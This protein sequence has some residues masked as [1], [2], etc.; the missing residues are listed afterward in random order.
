MRNPA[1][2]IF[3]TLTCN[4]NCT[5]CAITP[6]V[7]QTVYTDE[8]RVSP[9]RW[10]RILAMRSPKALFIT[11][12]EPLL[13]PG[14][15]MLVNA[16]R[17]PTWIYTNG[18][19][20]LSAL[21]KRIQDRSKL[22]VR[23][24]FHPHLG[25]G[26]AMRAAEVLRVARVTFSLH[27]VEVSSSIGKWV[28]RFYEHGHT[29]HLDP[30]FQEVSPW[31]VGGSVSCNVPNIVVGP[32]AR[33]Y[34]CTSKLTRRIGAVCDLNSNIELSPDTVYKCDEPEACCACDRAFVKR[35]VLT[36]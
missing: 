20:E 16:V 22:A 34:P 19:G 11:G 30:N 32:D 14:L 6:G 21:L 12:G 35:S 1:L 28:D 13:Y 36:T 24:S 4:G 18:T 27:A 15:E 10:A 9:E 5:F 33:V 25:F 31:A 17:C 3:P 23:L 7:G 26:T 8:R 2:H 29:L